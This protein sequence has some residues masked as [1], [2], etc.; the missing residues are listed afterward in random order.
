VIDALAPD[1]L[2]RIER[3]HDSVDRD[4]LLLGISD[5]SRV[6]NGFERARFEA[7]ARAYGHFHGLAVR[8]T[9]ALL[10]LGRAI[11]SE[12]R[13][14]ARTLQ[15]TYLE[16]ANGFQR[17]LR[18]RPVGPDPM[19]AD[20]TALVAG[21]AIDAIHGFVKWSRFLEEP[22]HSVP[23][24]QLHAL[25]AI[26]EA[27]QCSK[28]PI[29]VHAGDAV[30]A[31]VQ[32]LYLRTLA[33][34]L[35]DAGS[36]TAS[37]LE[38]ADG[39]FFA[40]CADFHLDTEYTS[41]QH[42]F[43]V[44]TVA[45]AGLELIHKVGHGETVRYLEAES[46]KAR[47]AQMQATLRDGH[48]Y[49]ATGSGAS[50]PV[51]EHVGVLNL[52]EKLHRSI[53]AASGNRIEERTHFQDREADVVVGTDLVLRKAHGIASGHVGAAPAA[54]QAAATQVIE[55]TASG[56]S[57]VEKPAGEAEDGGPVDPDV[58]R[59]RVFDMSTRGFGLLVDRTTADSVPLNGLIGL[60]NHE[61]GGWIVGTVVRKLPKPGETLVGVEILAYRPLPV[62]LAPADGGAAVPALYLAGSDTSGR[63]DALLLR[64]QDFR[65]DVAHGM[66]AGGA[67]Y[68]LRANRIVRKGAD[69]IK[70]RFE[71]E[72]KA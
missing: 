20:T 35:L 34:E 26:C 14:Y 6:D 9:V 55:F 60:R 72:S 57:L 28:L 1:R 5:R 22:G 2:L 49:A 27:Q 52:V 23:W 19:D 29:Q 53:L 59:W 7:L 33:L 50:F 70:A 10:R 4:A 39:W 64:A 43:C 66:Q 17:F 13:E 32:S 36:L 12:Q 16:A 46:L 47:L 38:I 24:R 21:L 61:T 42:I 8:D 63:L 69:W 51:E 31:T 48:L 37:Q 62:N 25:L 18:N 40:W 71:I 44:D 15:R 68:K 41:R 11:A 56:L 58:E 3:L 30:Q 65:P 67:G 54:V 45:D